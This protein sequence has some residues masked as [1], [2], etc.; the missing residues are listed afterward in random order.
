M[1]SILTTSERVKEFN[2]GGIFVETGCD[3]DMH[4]SGVEYL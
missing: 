2:A 4:P 1:I 3:G